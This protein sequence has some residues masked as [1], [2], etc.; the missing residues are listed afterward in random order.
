M[1]YI[2][3]KYGGSSRESIEKGE[4]LVVEMEAPPDFQTEEEYTKHVASLSFSEAKMFKQ[5]E[6][7]YAKYRR[8][9]RTNLLMVYN[10]LLSV[11][12]KGLQTRLKAE[13]TLDKPPKGMNRTVNLWNLIEKI[14][15]GNSMSMMDDAMGNLMTGIYDFLLLQGD[16]FNNPADFTKQFI[17]WYEV[18]KRGGFLLVSGELR[19]KMIE[20]M[21]ARNDILSD[22]YI[23]LEAWRDADMDTKEGPIA[24]TRGYIALT[25]AFATRV[26]LK[27]CGDRYK[28]MRNEYHNG[29][30]QGT[31]SY[32][33]NLGTLSRLLEFYRPPIAEKSGNQGN[34]EQHVQQGNGKPGR[35]LDAEQHYSNGR[36]HPCFRCERMGCMNRTCKETTKAD[37]SPVN[38]Q[39]VI[40]KKFKDLEDLS[41]KKKNEG[42]GEQQ[43]IEA[44][45]I[46]SSD[47][48][49]EAEEEHD[50]YVHTAFGFLQ[51]AD[52]IPLRF[53]DDVVAIKTKNKEQVEYAFWQDGAKITINHNSHE[54]ILDVTELSS[55]HVY[56]QVAAM[57]K[58]L[59]QEDLTE[60]EWA[61]LARKLWEVLLD[62]QSTCD[63]FVN[64][65]FLKNIRKCDWALRLRTQTGECRV[66]QIGD[67]PG[68]GTVW[69]YPEGIA[70]ILGQ[71]NMAVYS[72]W[73]IDY[74]TKTF[75][76]TQ[77][78]KDLSFKCV[79]KEGYQVCFEPTRQGLHVLDC[80]DKFGIDKENNGCVFG[81]EITDNGTDFG[82]KMFR[83]L[84]GE[85][86]TEIG[87]APKE[88]QK[89]SGTE[90]TG[91]PNKEELARAL[92]AG[93]TEDV[94]SR[95]E[96]LKDA[97]D[98]IE[99]S[100]KRYCKRDQD[101]AL[102]V[103]RFEHVAGH[104]SYK[105]LIRS[106]VT[107]G[108]KN[109]PITRRDIIISAEML[110]RSRYSIQGKTTKTQPEAVDTSNM[111]KVP[112]EILNNYGPVE[113]C[114][115][116]MH[117]NNIPFLTT[118]SKWVHYGTI[119]AV[120]N[121]KAATLE[122]AIQ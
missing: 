4:V 118:V 12:E 105:T 112:Q 38:S 40:D 25:D 34:G 93:V 46:P 60:E 17:N 1:N 20:E 109:S 21:D 39:E 110:G 91:V 84:P 69:F 74:S 32:P 37:G 59:Q 104:P 95:T 107:N 36:Q 122:G 70:N 97:I 98:T 30:L 63:I 51:D 103:R 87:E 62:S 114:V 18:A 28:H 48:L 8:S 113:L 31:M 54:I 85:S 56:N 50:G 64:A 42:T 80:S 117:C 22:T 121:M 73:D 3:T 11:C 75:K 14:C 29:Y 44:D 15:N 99:K 52:V 76:K 66:T 47:K 78:I 71:F 6:E 23:A 120:D 9:V 53:A 49:L 77:K 65:A 26:M 27:R 115:D 57:S 100:K 41:K 94:S 81:K 79:T 119:M 106:A 83:T 116:V 2:G 101:M 108:I 86:F 13:P 111:V 72:D 61:R 16:D 19:D 102:K 89:Q 55:N 45:V 88:E 58:R 33:N 7:D 92:L 68:V 82:K 96:L 10:F 35:D 67:L 5:D 24:C 43:M 90:L